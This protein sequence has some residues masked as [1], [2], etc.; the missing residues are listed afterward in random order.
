MPKAGNKRVG[1]YKTRSSEKFQTTLIC[2]RTC[3]SPVA[4]ALPTK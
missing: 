1:L 3:P 4:W 2:T